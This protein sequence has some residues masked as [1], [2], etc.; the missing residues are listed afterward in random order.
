MGVGR[1]LGGERRWWRRECTHHRHQ[2]DTGLYMCGNNGKTISG[3]EIIP[4]NVIADESGRATVWAVLLSFSATVYYLKEGN[5]LLVGYPDYVGSLV[6]MTL[7]IICVFSAGCF[8]HMLFIG[9]QSKGAMRDDLRE[10]AEEVRKLYVNSLKRLRYIETEMGRNRCALSSRGID[11]LGVSRRIINALGK[12][13]AELDALLSSGNAYD[14]MDAHALS[15]NKLVIAE[16]SIE[17]LI[18]AASIP[19]L[20]PYE[21]AP[22]LERLFEEVDVEMRKRA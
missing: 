13:S 4:R 17:A 16:N 21:W 8:V 20:A 11:C 3:R 9:E 15:G 6:L 14:L 1:R 5:K 7:G 19:P 18:D 22:T 10:F 12:R 2:V